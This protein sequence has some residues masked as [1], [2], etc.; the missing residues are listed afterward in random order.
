[1]C[2]NRR[3]LSHGEPTGHVC[4]P[5][6]AATAAAGGPLCCYA[7]ALPLCQHYDVLFCTALVWLKMD[8]STSYI[9]AYWGD[10]RQHNLRRRD[11]D[12]PL[13]SP[14]TTS[15]LSPGRAGPAQVICC[16]TDM[17]QPAWQ[18]RQVPNGGRGQ[19]MTDCAWRP[20]ISA[21]SLLILRRLVVA[22]R[23]GLVCP[24]RCRTYLSHPAVGD[25]GG[26]L[27][28][29]ASRAGVH[30]YIRHGPGIARAHLRDVR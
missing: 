26:G 18:R 20:T 23:L 19:W 22:A 15:P 9:G 3:R 6:A 13:V 14:T 7:D 4:R 17:A 11:P 24:T 30:S 8:C 25:D 27:W 16:L 21:V 10:G 5:A 29:S 12:R 2:R 28:V 1:M